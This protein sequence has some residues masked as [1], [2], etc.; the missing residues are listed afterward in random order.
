MIWTDIWEGFGH[1][2]TGIIRALAPLLV[3]FIIFQ[4]T[5]LKL[6]LSYIF[7]LLKGSLLA[8]AGLALFLQGVHIGFFPAGE[9][10]GQILGGI[11][12]QWALIPFGFMMGFLVTWGEP[13][14]RIL[15]SQVEE[16][17]SGSIQKRIVLY[18]ISAGVALFIALAMAKLVYGAPL[19]WII[20]PGYAI[21]I[22]LLFFSDKSVI[23]IA[24][25]AGGVATGPMAVTFLMAIAVGIASTIEGRD[26]V[27]DGF[28]LISLIAL[29]PILTTMTLGIIVRMKTQ[30]KEE[31]D[32]SELS[33]IVSIVR[34]G[35][36]DKILESSCKAGAEGGTI[37]FGRGIGVH[38][39]QKILGIPIEPEKEI[40][41]S[42]T[43]SNMTD[44]ILD[45]IMQAAELDKPGA[46][47]AFVVPIEKVV[48]IV[49][50]TD[51][52]CA[53]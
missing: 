48:G 1:T 39:K 49:H 37:M 52:S 5:V 15:S 28:G 25:D 29:A 43:D 17:S 7:N 26:P 44:A 42:V 46:G 41:L 9:Q 34:K 19:L 2:V 30:K 20:I 22:V 45:H 11:R 35:W 23:G 51:G 18:S 8:L 32:M 50:R 40:V 27:I 21:A 36:G 3:L 47:I 53:F 13:A 24:F 12:M 14:V 16:A 33:L 4:F 38:E 6:P 10:I 31:K